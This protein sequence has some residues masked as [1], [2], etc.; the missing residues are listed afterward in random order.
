MS[1]YF[2]PGEQFGIGGLYSVRAFK[3]QSLSGDRGFY[4]RNEL[5]WNPAGLE[6]SVAPQLWGVPGFFLGL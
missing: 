1:R 4:V 2:F 6:N 3:E 5:H